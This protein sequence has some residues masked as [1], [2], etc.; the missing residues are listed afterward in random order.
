M[1]RMPSRIILA[2]A[3]VVAST[4][5]Q[6]CKGGAGG[7]S[8]DTSPTAPS[9]PTPPAPP[10]CSGTPVGGVEININTPVTVSVFGET[11]DVQ[12]A[13]GQSTFKIQRNVVPCDY[14]LT[15]QMRPGTFAIILGFRR[16][17][18]PRANNDTGG[19]DSSST[20][21]DQGGTGTVPNPSTPC[22]L[23]VSSSGSFRVRFKVVSSNGCIPL[24]LGRL[25]RSRIGRTS[26]QPDRRSK[27]KLSRYAMMSVMLS[28]RT[29]TNRSAVQSLIQSRQGLVGQPIAR[30]RNVRD[31]GAR[32]PLCFLRLSTIASVS[33]RHFKGPDDAA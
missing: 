7:N 25:A 19:I 23:Q 29:R 4:L 3:I 6:S 9:L 33:R 11:F 31:F 30:T 10:G 2:T 5:G 22:V 14:E 26:A 17:S 1:G 15:G 12:Q 16:T 24:D 18:D 28:P 27:P 32:C 8:S 21:V 20:I 13:S